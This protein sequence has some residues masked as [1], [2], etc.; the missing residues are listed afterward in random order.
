ML[1]SF[2]D[3]DG[4]KSSTNKT[5]IWSLRAVGVATEK[6]II[7]RGLGYRDDASSTAQ[8]FPHSF[9]Q[10]SGPS[11]GVHCPSTHTQSRV[12]LN[13]F[14]WHIAINI[15]SSCCDSIIRHVSRFVNVN[16]VV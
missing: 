6:Y 11:V 13:T 14:T 1:P 12:L 5:L 3:Y 16:Y 15:T 2:S 7:L 8:R 10:Q 9:S 4:F